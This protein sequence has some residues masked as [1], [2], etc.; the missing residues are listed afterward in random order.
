V[1]KTNL[2]ALKNLERKPAGFLRVFGKRDSFSWRDSKVFLWKGMERGL[3][4][5]EW[6]RLQKEGDEFMHGACFLMGSQGGEP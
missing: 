6:L 3:R 5:E 2:N 4:G 1:G